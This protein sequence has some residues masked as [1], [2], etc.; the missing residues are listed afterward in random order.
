[1]RVL[2]SVSE[3]KRVTATLQTERVSQDLVYGVSVDCIKLAH[4]L[5][6]PANRNRSDLFDLECCRLFQ[7]IATIW[8]GHHVQ[9]QPPHR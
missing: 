6:E 7:T 4:S 2:S 1:M 5:P 8:L 9:R 3:G